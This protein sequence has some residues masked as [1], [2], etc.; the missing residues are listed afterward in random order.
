MAGCFAC[1]HVPAPLLV[2]RNAFAALKS[3]TRSNKIIMKGKEGGERCPN[4]LCE[5]NRGFIFLTLW[6]EIVARTVKDLEVEARFCPKPVCIFRSY[7]SVGESLDVFI[8]HD[9]L[10]SQN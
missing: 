10:C 5:W 4:A 9:A 7:D 8:R 3:S 2:S 6:G 1:V